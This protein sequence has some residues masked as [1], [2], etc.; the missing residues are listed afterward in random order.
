[1]DESSPPVSS[2]SRRRVLI[3]EDDF[4]TRDLLALILEDEGYIVEALQDG[5]E[6]AEHIRANR[7][8][9]IT[10]DMGLPGK[11]GRAIMEELG[12]DPSTANIPVVVISAHT[13]KLTE[14]IRDHASYVIAKPFYI[15]QVLDE[16]ERALRGDPSG[17]ELGI[18][19]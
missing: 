4:D 9:V 2:Q 3:I 7:P 12:Q 15:P 8:D 10:L 17:G 1:M 19:N 5:R 6:V 11:S 18:K 13:R 16:I 14:P